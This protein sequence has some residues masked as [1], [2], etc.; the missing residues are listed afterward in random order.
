ALARSRDPFARLSPRHA[1]ADVLARGRPA[2][3]A[4]ARQA[5]AHHALAD[6]CRPRRRVLSGSRH[7]RGRPAGPVDAA[8][9]PRPRPPRPRPPGRDRRAEPPHRGVPVELLPARE[10][11]T[12]RGGGG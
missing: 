3:L 1:S 2:E 9:L 5:T 7:A 10:P 12:T 4:R 11:P 6:D 8:R